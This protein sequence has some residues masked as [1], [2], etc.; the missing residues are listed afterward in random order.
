MQLYGNEEYQNADRL[1]R[2]N[3]SSNE[4]GP[5]RLQKTQ[6]QGKAI[7][8]LM[9]LF[10]KKLKEKGL[11][12]IKDAAVFALKEAKQYADKKYSHIIVDESQDLT[13]STGIYFLSIST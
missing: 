6:I 4:E 10:N 2:M 11:I 5:Q 8:E 3:K 9:L 12:D 13:R 7:F 1:G